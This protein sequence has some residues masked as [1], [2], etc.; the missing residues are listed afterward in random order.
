MEVNTITHRQWIFKQ[1]RDLWQLVKSDK[2]S[3]E[4][5]SDLINL[6]LLDLMD[7]LEAVLHK[8]STRF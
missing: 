6:E 7:R 3:L 5:G 2:N 8:T 1:E 4:L